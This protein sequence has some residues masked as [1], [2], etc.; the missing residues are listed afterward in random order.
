MNKKQ[1]LAAGGAAAVSF[2]LAMPAFADTP[3]A[4]PS[5]TQ[6][7]SHQMRKA[8]FYKRAGVIGTVTAVNGSSLTVAGKDGTTYAVDASKAKIQKGYGTTAAPLAVSGIAVNDTVAVKGAVTGTSVVAKRI[9][10]GIPATR[11][12]QKLP[13]ATLGTISSINGS[14]I[15]LTRHLKKGTPT[16]VTVTTNGATIYKKNGQSDTVNDLAVG[17]KIVA[18]GV[19]DT[20]GN[21]SNATSV[22]MMVR[23]LRTT[24][25]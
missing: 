25:P 21:I 10:D 4:N 1:I 8:G 16:T 11:T 14:S 7:P 18:M 17:Q 6:H 12:H 3:T 5:I 9:A 19:K 13:N 15:T 22:N 20:S 24:T 2:L 23:T